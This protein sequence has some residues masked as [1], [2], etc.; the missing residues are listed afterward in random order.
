MFFQLRPVRTGLLA[1]GFTVLI[2]V[3]G[4]GLVLFSSLFLTLAAHSH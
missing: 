4:V 1:R 2:T 3:A